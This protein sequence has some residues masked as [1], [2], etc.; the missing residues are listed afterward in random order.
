MASGI[1]GRQILGSLVLLG[2]DWLLSKACQF[3]ENSQMSGWVWFIT[4]MYIILAQVEF[5]PLLKVG[6]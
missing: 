4:G 6:L 1:A 5:M 2:I 3:R